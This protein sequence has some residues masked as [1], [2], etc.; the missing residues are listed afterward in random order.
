MRARISKDGLFYIG[1][2][3]GIL[4]YSFLGIPLPLPEQ[5]GWK[6]VTKKCMTKLQAKEELKKWKEESYPEEF[7]L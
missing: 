6:K 4:S 5:E 3:Y 2:V 7:E 1:E